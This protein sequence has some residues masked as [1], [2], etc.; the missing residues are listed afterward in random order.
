MT[1]RTLILGNNL[2]GLVTAYRLLHY[3]FHL[4]ILDIHPEVQSSAHLIPTEEFSKQASPTHPLPYANDPTPL[5][6]HGFYHATLALLQELSIEWPAQNF[7]AVPLEFTSQGKIPIGLPH[8][9]RFAWIH[10]LT[11]LPFFKGLSWTDRW[12]M[13]N[14]L[15]KQ[16]EESSLSQRQPDIE[17]VETWLITAKQSPHSRS[18]FWNPLC[19]FLLTCDLREASLNSFVEVLTRYW[20]GHRSDAQTF[21]TPPNTLEK[22]ETELRQRLTHYGVQFHSTK[23][24]VRLNVDIESMQPIGLGEN[25]LTAQAY[26][27]TLAPKHLLSLL[28]ERLLARFSYFSSLAQIKESFGLAIQF[29]LP[30]ILLDF[31]LILHANPFD[32][33][34]SQSYLPLKKPETIVTCVTLQKSV[35]QKYTEDYWIDQGW[36]NIQYHF[37]LSVEEFQKSCIP[38]IIRSVGPFFPCHCGARANRPLPRTPIRNFFLAGPWTASAFPASVENTIASANACAESIAAA[39]Y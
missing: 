16:W 8:A 14:F 30:G 31:R 2:A 13:I 36:T 6:L 4:T 15:E 10:P 21:L 18:H 9:F 26:V 24:R 34:T 39:F 17:N 1:P 3:G 32:W 38:K 20:F 12:H 28:P 35:D 7:Q 5:I 19:R 29:T 27:S 23:K 33:I 25:Q 22:L 37:K 11:R